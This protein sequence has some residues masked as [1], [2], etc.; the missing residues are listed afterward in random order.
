MGVRFPAARSEGLRTRR[1]P[2]AS[3]WRRGCGRSRYKQPVD[4][5]QEASRR[6][7]QATSVPTERYGTR[8]RRELRRRARTTSRQVATALKGM[9]RQCRVRLGRT[10]SSAWRRLIAGRT[11]GS[12][13]TTPFRCSVGVLTV[14]RKCR[15]AKANPEPDLRYRSNANAR[16]SSLNAMTTSMRHGRPSA[17][18][19]QWPAL[20][21]ARRAST[22]AVTPV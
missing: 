18:C 20:C 15:W 5:V 1:A 6:V 12:S 2:L 9:R 21:A 19:G 7:L 13:L 4:C 10:I 11:H 14:L 3:G 17:V 8:R 16:R 22:S